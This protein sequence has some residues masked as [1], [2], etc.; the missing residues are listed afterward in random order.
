MSQP[1]KILADFLNDPVN[2]NYISLLKTTINT[3]NKDYYYMEIKSASLT[4]VLCIPSDD[5][6]TTTYCSLYNN[7]TLCQSTLNRFG[8]F[9]SVAV[10]YDKD[11]TIHHIDE[12]CTEERFF[13]HST[14]HDLGIEFEDVAKIEKFFEDVRECSP[15]IYQNFLKQKNSDT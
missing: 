3:I 1:F 10:N 15:E 11:K 7:V 2:K 8:S 4:I 6:D 14:V 9:Y 12:L 13:Q 5:T